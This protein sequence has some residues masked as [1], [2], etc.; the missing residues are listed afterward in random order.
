LVIWCIV[1]VLYY[2]NLRL[3]IPRFIVCWR[4]DAAGFE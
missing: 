3:Y 2:V 4:L 1:N